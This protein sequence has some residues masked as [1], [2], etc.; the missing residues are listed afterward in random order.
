MNRIYKIELVCFF[1][2]TSLTFLQAEENSLKSPNEPGIELPPVILDLEDTIIESVE[3]ALPDIELPNAQSVQVQLPKVQ[4]PSTGL[5]EINA[6]DDELV[7]NKPEDEQKNY[8]DLKF[9]LG[10]LMQI[11]ANFTYYHSSGD[12]LDI[13]LNLFHDSSLFWD[14]KPITNSAIKREEKI[15]LDLDYLDDKNRVDFSFG[16]DEK[17][18]WLQ[19]QVASE[20]SRTFR[21]LNIDGEYRY[22]ANKHLFLK[23]RIGMQ[24]AI[25]NSG[26][27]ESLIFADTLFSPGF[28]LLLDK[29][30]FK[31]E[32]DVDYQL[33]SSLDSLDS[34]FQFMTKFD[35]ELPKN[36]GIAGGLGLNWSSDPTTNGYDSDI[37]GLSFPFFA[38]LYG[39]PVDF[40]RFE[41]EGGFKSWLEDYSEIRDKVDWIDCS[42][43]K[44]DQGWFFDTKLYWPI[45]KI[46]ELS[47]GLEYRKSVNQMS[48]SGFTTSLFSIDQISASTLYI[49]AGA[50]VKPIE[51]ISLELLWRGEVLSDVSYLDPQ[52]RLNF[53]FDYTIPKKWFGGSAILQFDVYEEVQIPEL[54]LDFF[55]EVKKGY[56]II[57]AGND[58]LSP[59]YENGRPSRGLFIEK[60]INV[61]IMA[62]ISL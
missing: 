24:S 8:Y 14:Y 21:T 7:L 2:L 11:Y 12:G 53:V 55:F 61:A 37:F 29:N 46:A 10:S 40:F 36:L 15:G 16:Y 13:E 52:H 1:I 18:I 27:S 26:Y 41:V 9:G 42:D 30:S 19:N 34:F 59:I 57:I 23:A 33:G 35:V 28:G 39:K 56:K 60:G 47:T 54:S 17:Q 49:F 58:L 22:Q 50:K 6:T 43:I 4:S 38:K 31:F 3:T 32:V 20:T 44:I 25:T 62:D 45:K 51:E 5:N 48:L